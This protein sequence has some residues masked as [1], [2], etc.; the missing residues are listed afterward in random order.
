MSG[1]R[2]GIMMVGENKMR[3]SG[4]IGVMGGKWMCGGWLVVEKE[5]GII[6]EWVRIGMKEG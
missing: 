3:S 5:V 4:R 6:V 1:R 2:G